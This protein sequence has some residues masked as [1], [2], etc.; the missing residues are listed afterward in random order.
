MSKDTFYFSH[1]YNSRNDVKIKKLLS[2]HGLLGYGIFWAIIE[3]LYNNTNVLPT[4]YDTISFDL[5][6][7]KE[8]LISIVNDFE[9]FVFENNTFGSLSVQK[10]LDE[11][12]ERSKKA[13]DSVN[14]RWEKT[15]ENTNVLQLK[16]D[17][18]TIKEKKVNKK[19]VNKENDIPLFSVFLEYAKTKKPN[20]DSEKLSLKYSAW[21]ENDWRDGNGNKI[22]NWKTKLLN[23]LPY[24]D[25]VNKKKYDP[26]NP[27]TFRN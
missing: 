18:N 15:K 2:K 25:E 16:Y 27:A 12:D 9:L 5:R 26:T 11:R 14:K 23:T 8:V 19:K 3:E 21:I 6:I 4:D 22:T 13:R 20:V 10:R 17:T 7:D 1:D 24:I